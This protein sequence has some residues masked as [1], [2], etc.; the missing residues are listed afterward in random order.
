MPQTWHGTFLDHMLLSDFLE[1]ALFKDIV[2][3]KLTG[4]YVL[5]GHPAEQNGYRENRR[6]LYKIGKWTENIH[7][8]NFYTGWW[9]KEDVRIHYIWTAPKRPDDKQ[10]EPI[11]N[12]REK[13]LR[14]SL[15]EISSV[16]WE[17]SQL[18]FYT[19]IWRIMLK[20]LA[21]MESTHR[22]HC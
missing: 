14:Q 11:S 13:A 5:S 4:V 6:T 16:T 2:Q 7:R 9:R 8:L 21:K 17:G 15:R 10:G 19:C 20:A 22:H 1:G 12:R 3:R 18:D